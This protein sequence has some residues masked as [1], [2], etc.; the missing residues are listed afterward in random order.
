MKVRSPTSDELPRLQEIEVAAGVAFAEIGLGDVAAAD[1]FTIDELEA[2]RRAGRIW[3]LD[4]EGTVAGYAV[5][6]VLDDRAHLEQVSLHPE[7]GR[8]GLGR[9]LVEHVC[10][11]AAQQGMDAVTLTTF[12]DVPW[13]APLYERYGFSVLVDDAL[14]PQLRARR[15]READDGL[16]LELRVCM[17]RAVP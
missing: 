16:D 7:W 14:G 2:Y 5:V 3:V 9:R 6:D 10:G 8:R 11:W 1:P 13:N 17:V 4:D 15:A 12:R